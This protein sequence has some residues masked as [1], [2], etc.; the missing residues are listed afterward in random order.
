MADRLGQ[1][2][3]SIQAFAAALERASRMIGQFNA[4]SP[5]GHSSAPTLEGTSQGLPSI[6]PSVD[7]PLHPFSSPCDPM[8]LSEHP[9]VHS[10]DVAEQG[11]SFLPVLF[12]HKSGLK[13][14]V[15][16][17]TGSTFVFAIGGLLISLLVVS[18]LLGH[19]QH[20][21]SP[22]LGVRIVP[23]GSFPFDGSDFS[24]GG[25]VT[26]TVDG[27]PVTTVPVKS[28]GTFDVT[29]RIDPNWPAGSS[30]V[31]VFTEAG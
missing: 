29:L 2:L 22:I 19:G 26:V 15:P 13:R 3:D 28:D 6:S 5:L 4:T 7:A 20:L 25:T 18:L 9:S 1:Q 8:A 16:R 21:P 23:G 17:I 10:N 11:Q 14:F 24:P 27:Q 12:G 30:H 31:Y